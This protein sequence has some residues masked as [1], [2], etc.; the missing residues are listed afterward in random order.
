[1]DSNK[2]TDKPSKKSTGSNLTTNVTP[3]LSIQAFL[4][5]GFLGEVLDTGFSFALAEGTRAL[6]DLAGAD[7]DVDLVTAFLA[8]DAAV[9]PVTVVLAAPFLVVAFLAEV[10][11]FA[12]FL[13]AAPEDFAFLDEDAYFLLVEADLAV[14]RLVFVVV[15]TLALDLVTGRAGVFLAVNVLAGA[16]VDFLEAGLETGLL[17]GVAFSLAASLRALGASLTFPDGPFGRRK[18]PFSAPWVM[19]LLSWLAAVALRSIR[20]LISTNFL[21]VGRETPARASSGCAIMHSFIISTQVG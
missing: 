20:Y 3:S 13:A 12:G 7:L 15:A 18:V 17:A 19:A 4:D 16:A 9:A 11:F 14:A 21:M 5:T 2:S 8:L 6:V 1:M 10:V